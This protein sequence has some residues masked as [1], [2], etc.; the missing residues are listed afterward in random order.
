MIL[1]WTRPAL[2]DLSEI[3]DFL[4]ARNPVAAQKI[5]SGIRT[6]ANL[7]PHHPMMGRSGRIDGTRELVIGKTPFVIA[8]RVT[9][10]H[11]DILAVRHDH[12][13][14]PDKLAD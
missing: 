7:L 11:V 12:R 6:R 8:Y 13:Q 10:T 1:R 5:L 2:R 14:W 3:F 4:A 9:S